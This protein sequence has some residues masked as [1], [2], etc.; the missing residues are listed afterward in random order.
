MIAIGRAFLSLALAA[1]VAG[2]SMVPTAGKPAKD[3]DLAVPSHMAYPPAPDDA[4]LYTCENGMKFKATFSD[5]N[6]SV[7]IEPE[8]GGAYVLFISATGSGFDYRDSGRDLR[9]KGDEAMWTDKDKP[10]TKCTATP[11]G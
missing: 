11:A 9:G 2:C 7:R 3:P 10:T 4:V 5:D 1:I 8:G 6:G